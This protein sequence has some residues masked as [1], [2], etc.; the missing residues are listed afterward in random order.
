MTK[1]IRLLIM[2][3]ILMGVVIGMMQCAEKTV[4]KKKAHHENG[5]APMPVIYYAAHGPGTGPAA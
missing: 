5:R 1:G 3:F 2:V 4:Q